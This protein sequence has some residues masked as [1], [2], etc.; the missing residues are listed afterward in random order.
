MKVFARAVVV[1]V[2]VVASLTLAAPAFANDNDIPGT[3]ITVNQVVNDVVDASTD[4]SDVFTVHLT[5]GQEVAL[6]IV[7]TGAGVSYDCDATL[8][9]PSSSSVRW[10]DGYYRELASCGINS[11]LWSED[12]VFYVPART[13]NYHVWVNEDEA[14]CPYRLVVARTPRAAI[15]TPDTNDIYGVAV[16]GGFVDGVVDHVMDRNDVYAVK[17]TAGKVAHF[18]ITWIGTDYHYYATFLTVFKLLGPKSTSVRHGARFYRSLASESLCDQI[19]HERQIDYTPA[20]SGTYYLWIHEDA[21]LG[22]NCLYEIELGGT[23]TKPP[24]TV[25]LSLTATAKSVARGTPVTLTTK[26]RTLWGNL[27]PNETLTL[28]RCFPKRPWRS[29][30]TLTSTTGE[31]STTITPSRTASYHVRSSGNSSYRPARSPIVRVVVQ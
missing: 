10:G 8:L 30:G 9:S 20:V 1:G 21:G 12:Q 14:N 31:Y 28:T 16:G 5:A 7:Y 24:E 2:A 13:G 6:D 27:V 25:R 4:P 17:L 19:Y 11:M 15:I 3:T 26:M 29:I 23:V 22:G 18:R